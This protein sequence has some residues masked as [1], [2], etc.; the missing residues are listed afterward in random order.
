MEVRGR[1][2]ADS[3]VLVV[4]VVPVHDTADKWAGVVD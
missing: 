3:E 1:V 4:I 2:E